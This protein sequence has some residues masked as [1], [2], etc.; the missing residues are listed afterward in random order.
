M[1]PRRRARAGERR[2][3]CLG[4]LV[5]GDRRFPPPYGLGA[6]WL[7]FSGSRS[8]VRLDQARGADGHAGVH[9]ALNEAF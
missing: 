2:E 8:T 1:T 5:G 3:Q 6:R 9:V 4:G 7:L